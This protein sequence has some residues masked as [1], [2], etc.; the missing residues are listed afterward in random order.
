MDITFQFWVPLPA[1]SALGINRLGHADEHWKVQKDK[2]GSILSALSGFWRSPPPESACARCLSAC[3][4][5]ATCQQS[6]EM[7]FG[8]YA[9]VV[10]WSAH[11]MY[12]HSM[13][14]P[15]TRYHSSGCNVAGAPLPRTGIL[16][17][18]QSK[19]TGD[20]ACRQTAKPPT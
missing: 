10:Q 1:V 15:C 19:E 14:F 2:P 16:H 3:H 9:Y 5:A 13:Y 6:L 18:Q 20:T 17:W 7:P 12:F 11:S 8:R 4:L